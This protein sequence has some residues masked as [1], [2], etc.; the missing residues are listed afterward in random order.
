M[1]LALLMRCLVLVLAGGLG[2][3]GCAGGT[4]LPASPTPVLLV[5]TPTLPAAGTAVP[6]VALSPSAAAGRVIPHP[7]GGHDIV[8]QISGGVGGMVPPIYIQASRFPGFTVFGDGTLIYRAGKGFYQSRL[9]E[10]ALQRLLTLAVDDVHF[11]TLD[12]FNGPPCCDMPSTNVTLAA[13]GQRR[14]VSVTFAEETTTPTGS[15][16]SVHRLGRLLTALNALRSET[17]PAYLPA[18]VT[19]YA[20]SRPASASDGA[21]PHWPVSEIL[22]ARVLQSAPDRSGGSLRVTGPAAQAALRAAPDPQPFTDAGQG[23]IVVAVPDSP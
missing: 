14:S 13:D 16:S 15:E 18:G 2:L 11:F 20:E 5:A 23:Y 19:I 9:D 3:A 7:A 6:T 1:R 10:A 17:A 22:L 21:I 12:Q 4:A 8:I